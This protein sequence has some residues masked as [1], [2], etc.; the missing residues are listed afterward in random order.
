MSDTVTTSSDRLDELSGIIRQY[1]D[2]TEKLQQSHEQL[3][4]TVQ[5]L[6]SDL[7]EK[8]RQLERKNRLAALGE[9]A[10]GM[11]HEIR[12]PLGGIQLY[13]SLLAKDLCG[14]EQPLTLVNKI[15]AGVTRLERVVSH[16][17]QFT[18]E[19]SADVQETDAAEAIDHALEMARPAFD[20]ARVSC[21]ASG[22]RPLKLRLD[23]TLLGQ[24]ALNLLLNSAEAMET[25]GGTVT[26][27]WS[28]W[29]RN[30]RR[31][32][33]IVRDTGPGVPAHLLDRIFNPFFTTKETGTGLGLA[34]VHRIVEAHD[35]TISVRNAS[36]GGALFEMRI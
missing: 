9:M 12:N 25:T 11:A 16:V 7:A 34:I 27:R 23:G 15:S 28:A 20:A 35:G 3:Q 29:G 10:A 18:R 31:L 17:L 8:N 30:D 13:A 4:R 2:V 14:L 5:S 6:R 32:K 22:P 24:A 26:V 19:M 21:D 33:L 36:G 1:N